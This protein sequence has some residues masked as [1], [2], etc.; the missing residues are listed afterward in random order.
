TRPLYIAALRFVY[1]HLRRRFAH[2]NL[3]AFWICAACS[4]SCAVSCPTVNFSSAIAARWFSILLCCSSTF[5]CSLRHSFSNIEPTCSNRTV[6]T[7]PSLSRKTSS[8]ATQ[9]RHHGGVVG[10]GG[11]AIERV[12]TEG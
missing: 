10:T 2:L 5:L 7:L 3:R 6:F 12:I 11:N 9:P 4:L 1:D 8:G